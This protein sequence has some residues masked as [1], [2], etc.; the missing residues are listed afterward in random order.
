[1]ANGGTDMKICK[2]CDNEVEDRMWSVFQI[3][4]WTFGFRQ[5]EGC[6]RCV[7][8]VAC[9]YDDRDWDHVI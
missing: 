1:M 2:H 3:T 9:Q 8:T 6:P 5:Y 7:H 4:H